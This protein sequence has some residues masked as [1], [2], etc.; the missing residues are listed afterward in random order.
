MVWVDL[1]CKRYKA[2][3]PFL[4]YVQLSDDKLEKIMRN[5]RKQIT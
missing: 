1:Q 3:L 5:M 2:K 4:P